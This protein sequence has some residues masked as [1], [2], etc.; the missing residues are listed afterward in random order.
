M[1]PSAS[2]CEIPSSIACFAAPSASGAAAAISAAQRAT[3]AGSSADGTTSDTI[4]SSRARAAPM[5]RPVKIS[6][7]AAATPAIRARRC[8]P[9]APG[10]IPS[11]ASVRPI[12]APSA[13]IRMSQASASS[14]PPPNATPFT[15]A[16]VGRGNA[17]S[18]SMSALISPRKTRVS[19]SVQVRRSFRSAPDENALSPPP[20][21]TSA[22]RSAPPAISAVSLPRSLVSSATNARDS[23]FAA[24]GRFSVT[25]TI[26]PRRSTSSGASGPEVSISATLSDSAAQRPPTAGGA[27]E[28]EPR[29]GLAARTAAIAARSPSGSRRSSQKNDSPEGER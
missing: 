28:L 1:S 15:A 26:G 21:S 12:S 29:G 7:F 8:V 2:E 25:D 9:P 19:S 4:P 23:A 5:R 20:V 27:A 22:R 13:A 10:M 3:A 14:S 11:R 16:M 17:A 18:V 24:A 6:S